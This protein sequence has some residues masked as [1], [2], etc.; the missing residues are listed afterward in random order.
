MATPAHRRSDQT[1]ERNALRREQRPPHRAQ[2]GVNGRFHLSTSPSTRYVRLPSP[3]GTPQNHLTNKTDSLPRTW[4][5]S[6]E[7]YSTY[8]LYL[9][10]LFFALNITLASLPLLRPQDP[11]EDI[12]LTPAQRHYLN[13]PPMTRPATPQEQEQYVTPPRYSRSATPQSNT[14]SLRGN[15]S[16]SPLDSSLRRSTSG[17]PFG[18]GQIQQQHRA[19]PFGD[20][21][22]RR[23]S[24]QSTRSS[25]LSTSEFD[26]VGSIS[27]PTKSSKASVG[28]NSKWLY[29]KG[30]G[31]P[32]GSV[33]SGLA[34]WGGGGSVFS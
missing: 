12:P 4:L 19:S 32:R 18:G 29:E 2:H 13:L 34:G 5:L 3:P 14:S 31:S 30:R 26:A 22:R 8:T 28:L 21:N 20:S 33:G 6:T 24:F 25:P 27:T 9:L 16:D 1:P 11:C 15:A 17:S 7:P 10:R 23:L